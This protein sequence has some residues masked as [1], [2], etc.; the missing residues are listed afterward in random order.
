MRIPNYK[1]SKTYTNNRWGQYL[2][3]SYSSQSYDTI[4]IIEL[5]YQN[6]FKVKILPSTRPYPITPRKQN[7]PSSVSSQNSEYEFERKKNL[8]HFYLKQTS[9]LFL[10]IS[11]LFLYQISQRFHIKISGLNLI[12]ENRGF[13][14]IYQKYMPFEHSNR[15]NDA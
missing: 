8:E 14:F 7:I 6:I 5:K 3:I 9:Q 13:F 12:C 15:Q 2:K 11:Q 4:Y 1:L 10:D